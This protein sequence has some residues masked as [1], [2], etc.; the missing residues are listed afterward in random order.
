MI[1]LDTHVW[2]WLNGAVE[3]LSPEVLDLLYSPSTDI[4]L[5]AASAWEIGIKVSSGKLALPV[6]P[7]EY[8][9]LRMADNGARPLPIQHQ[10][11]LRAAS[12]PLRSPGRPEA[13]MPLSAPARRALPRP[14][15]RPPPRPHRPARRGPG[16]QSPRAAFRPGEP[17]R[18]VAERVAAA[19][20]IQQ[21]RFGRAAST[22]VN[23][24]MGPE[25]LRRWC[26]VDDAGRAM[27]DRSFEKLGLSA[28]ALDRILKVA[29][30]IADLGGN[31]T[32][33]SS[34]VAEAIQYRSLDRRVTV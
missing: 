22:P 13:P 29:R 24:A 18:I 10:H 34:H 21:E 15:V 3:R 20:L 31:E 7:E 17:T 8:I 9:P 6:A 28:R 12:L 30:T 16:H 2:L 14:H 33:R 11:A 19:R 25:A 4:Y 26:T 32:I 27:L 5:S 1:L 23:A